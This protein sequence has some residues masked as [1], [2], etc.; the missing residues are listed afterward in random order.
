VALNLHALETCNRDALHRLAEVLTAERRRYRRVW[1]GGISRGGHLALSCLAEQPE[2]LDGLCLL[3][4]YPG[5]RLTTNAIRRAGGLQ[6]WRAT[7]EQL[8]D[9]EFRLWHWLQRPSVPVP[10][11][12][13]WGEQDRFVDG[14]QPLRDGLPGADARSVPGEH[15]WTAWL[16]LWEQFLGAGHFEVKP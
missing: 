8:L 1:L 5:S 4:P 11:F 9:P 12:I 13:G 6:A 15:D 14:M 7:E 2:L 16:P 3:A 10:L